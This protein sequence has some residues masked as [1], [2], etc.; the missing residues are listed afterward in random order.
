M[1][2]LPRADPL[3]TFIN[4]ARCSLWGRCV[5]AG[6]GPG[7]GSMRP[8]LLSQKAMRAAPSR[9]LLTLAQHFW[10]SRLLS[11][12]MKARVNAKIRTPAFFRPIAR[13]SLTPFKS[14]R[15]FG[16]TASSGACCWAL[17]VGVP[18]P[19]LWWYAAVT[20]GLIHGVGVDGLGSWAVSQSGALTSLYRSLP[21]S[22]VA[23][24]AGIP[25]ILPTSVLGSRDLV[26]CPFPVASRAS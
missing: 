12:Y 15:V 22:P 6:P 2:S 23:G 25:K 24:S 11:A 18:R 19:A 21:E 9:V 7:Q 20:A 3:T 26:S 1:R 8:Q 17:A 14:A 4:S 5:P 13:L 10:S 16:Q